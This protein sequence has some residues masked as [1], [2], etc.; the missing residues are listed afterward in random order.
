VIQKDNNISE[1]QSVAIAGI[2]LKDFHVYIMQEDAPHKDKI[3]ISCQRLE[4]ISGMFHIKDCIPYVCSYYKRKNDK[5]CTD[6]FIL[7]EVNKLQGSK[8]Q[9]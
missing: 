4:G 6:Y 1:K 2:C 9:V 7:K 3:D 8:E 5:V